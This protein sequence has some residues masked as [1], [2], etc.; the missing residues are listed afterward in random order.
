[1]DHKITC[2]ADKI[3]GNIQTGFSGLIFA[4]LKMG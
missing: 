3:W 4:N 1:M 2:G